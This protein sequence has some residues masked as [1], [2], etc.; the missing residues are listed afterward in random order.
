MTSEIV[1]ARLSYSRKNEDC[2]KKVKKLKDCGDSRTHFIR[3]KEQP[4]DQL[5]LKGSGHG[6][7][8]L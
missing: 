6:H 4:E 7:P 2:L 3:E 5:P 8:Y 1:Q